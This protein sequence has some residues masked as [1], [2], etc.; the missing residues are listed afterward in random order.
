MTSSVGIR[1]KGL[2]ELRK[3]FRNIDEA[4]S[5]EGKGEL[6][7]LN[8]AVANVVLN[9]A[10]EKMPQVSGA[11]R[12]SYHAN[13]VI[14]G[15]KVS[16]SLVYAGVSEFGGTIPRFHSDSRTHH[17]PPAPNDSYYIY[18]AAREKESEIQSMYE[19]GIGRLL[20]KYFG[21]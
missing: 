19:E 3:G 7:V 14:S 8:M 16:S 20:D 15:A 21:G 4:L 5:A 9:A 18:P 1:V 2:K 17:K 13:N 11:L 12:E 10:R 6:K